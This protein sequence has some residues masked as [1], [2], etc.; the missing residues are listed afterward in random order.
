MGEGGRR[1]DEGSYLLT[2][3]GSQ[4]EPSPALSG[5]LSHPADGRG[6][7]MERPP[8]I[9]FF[10]IFRV[11]TL[12]PSGA[13]HIATRCVLLLSHSA[14]I[15]IARLS[16]IHASAGRPKITIAHSTAAGVDT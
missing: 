6:G 10:A 7:N 16:Q 12:Y 2:H 1:P 9:R 15:N 4:E 13:Y 3:F 5:T 11:S 8:H 14:P